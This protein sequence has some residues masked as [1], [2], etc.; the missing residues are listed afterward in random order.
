[1]RRRFCACACAC[2]LLLVLLSGCAGLLPE[3]TDAADEAILRVV[4]LSRSDDTLTLVAVTAGGQEEDEAQ[5]ESLEG[6]GADYWSAR[7]D[8]KTKRRASLAHATVW[9]VE[10]N[11]LADALEAFVSDPQLTYSAHLYLL[12]DQSAADFLAAFPEDSSGPARVL[13]AMTL[14]LGE[15]ALTMLALSAR[16][17]QQLP[18]T[19]FVVQAQ[20]GSVEVVDT[21]EVEEWM[22]SS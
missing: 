7:A 19:L 8:L 9:V 13:D 11:A 15:Q 6:T 3:Q 12:G 17:A 2:A 22:Q 20:D 18:C 10:E 1:M 14:A 4:T 21:V 5:V 16:L